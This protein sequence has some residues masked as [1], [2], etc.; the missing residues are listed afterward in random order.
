M[1]DRRSGVRNEPESWQAQAARFALI[2]D[3]VLLIAQSNDLEKLLVGAVNKIKWVLDFDRCLLALRNADEST[4]W[5]RTLMETRRS[6]NPIEEASLP[7]ADGLAGAVMSSG[8]IRAVNDVPD[9][10]ADMPELNDPAITGAETGSLLALPVEAYGRNL[11]AIAFCARKQGVFSEDDI[12]VAVQFTTHLGL[13][14]DRYQQTEALRREIAERERAEEALAAQARETEAARTQLSEAIDAI[15][16][17]FVL[18]DD[19]DRL[20]LC[21]DRFRDFFGK[22]GDRIHQGIAFPYLI[23]AL[24]DSGIVPFGELT[25][26]EW[27]T[28][29]VA[30]HR[31]P[32]DPIE[33]KLNNGRWVRI[34]ERPTADGGIVG[35]Y[36]D[37][38][39]LKER[40]LQLGE[41]V[42]SLAQ[43]RDQAMEATRTKSQF[44]ANMSHELRTPLN[45]VIGI[46]EMLHE[47]AEDLGQDDFIE[48]LERINRA[49]KHLLNLINEILDLSKIEAGRIE[50]LS[51]DFEVT[52]LVEEIATVA[53][54]LADK[55]GNTLIL[56]IDPQAGGMR[57]DPTRMRQVVFN[58]V[59][60]ACKFTEK[61]E[62]RLT[63]RRES[64]AGEERMRFAVADTGIGIS[65][66]QMGRLF[67]EFSQADAST[68]RKYGGTG[69]GLAISRKLCQMMG[70]DIDVS[71]VL[72]E[73]TTFE[74][75]IP[76]YVPDLV[77]G[78]DNAVAERPAQASEGN[79]DSL[80]LVIDDDATVRELMQRH[81]AHD[82]IEVITAASGEEGL[83]KAREHRPGVITLDVLMPGMDGWSVLQTLKEDPQTATIPVV[84]VTILDD[85]NRGYALGAADYLNKPISREQIQSV[86]ARYI[87]R[88]AGARILVVEDDEPTRTMLRRL[89]VSEGCLVSEAGNGRHALQRLDESR[90]DLILLDLMMPEM[91]GFEFL[92]A[93][94]SHAE[95]A[96]VP[97]VVVTAA[98]LTL[99]DRARLNGG[100]EHILEKSALDGDTLIAE[101]RRQV[102]RIAGAREAE[103]EADG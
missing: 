74:A 15:S 17:G 49:G 73:G 45:A 76:V 11:G 89:L 2:S 83:V 75:V 97:V 51:E 25:K 68:T 87:A 98:D 3:V 27:V 48:P 57:A 42:D 13:A 35:V 26:E 43:A 41:L 102:D 71:S 5:L 40:E 80:V 85:R 12:K 92:S 16:E 66:E 22:V 52:G 90:P 33:M 4:Y 31:E 37:V 18:Y 28:G 36:S 62:V 79:N 30:T 84:M 32:R 6:A 60:N 61:G 29:R 63:V 103:T 86:I 9:R 7:V 64:G 96:S 53:R 44:L 38:T 47:D 69:L 19:D 99:A 34:T 54:P 72:G 70:G 67:Q 77:E 1:S 14:I 65:E 10:L 39:E 91:D 93:L 55:N 21:N 46:A 56:D 59:S 81:L 24:A 78:E 94:R 82:G 8:Q 23:A 100:V 95:C 50:M 88:P 101:I 58:L 20:V